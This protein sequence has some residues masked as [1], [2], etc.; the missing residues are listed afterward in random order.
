MGK[1]SDPR[2]PLA[3]PNSEAA[4]V[5]AAGQRSHTTRAAAKPDAALSKQAAVRKTQPR[6]CRK[7]RPHV[8][9]H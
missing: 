4:V 1:A 2:R 5:V 7:K 3:W 9:D 8:A 6:T